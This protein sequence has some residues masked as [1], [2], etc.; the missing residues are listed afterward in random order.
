MSRSFT[1]EGKS[2]GAIWVVFRYVFPSRVTATRIASLLSAA[3]MGMGFLVFTRSTLTPLD[4]MGVMTM[5]MMSMHEHHV[6][7]GGHVDV[8]HRRRGAVLHDN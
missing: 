8:G 7:H 2:A 6:D 1:L 4:N 3:C 5:K